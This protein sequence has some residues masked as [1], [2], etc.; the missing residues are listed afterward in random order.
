M[1]I[2]DKPFIDNVTSAEGSVVRGSPCATDSGALAATTAALQKA[3]GA[4]VGVIYLH[5]TL[6][7]GAMF[8]GCGWHCR[9]CIRNHRL[10]ERNLS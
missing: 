3:S 7:A 9:Q 5:P 8:D 4:C 6:V 2:N 10:Q 1:Q